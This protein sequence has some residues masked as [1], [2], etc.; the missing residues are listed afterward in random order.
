MDTDSG[1]TAASLK[2]LTVA[3]FYHVLTAIEEYNNPAQ[4]DLFSNA[5]KSFAF[6]YLSEIDAEFLTQELNLKE[7]LANKILALL[8][9]T[10]SLAFEIENLD[11]QGIRLCTVFDGSYPTKLKAQ[12]ADM[13]NSL[14]EPPLL[15]CCGDLSIAEHHFAGFV[16][17]RNVD[18]S[19]V[20]WTREAVRRIQ[21]RAE[22]ENR[23]FGIVSGGAE[24]ID[25]ASEEEALACRMPV[26]E[27]SKSMRATL[28][29]SACINAIM[30]DGMLLLS[31]IN[32][33]RTLSRMDATA[34]FMNRNKYIYAM[35]DYTIVVK[36]EKGPK[37]GTWAGATEA[38]K[39]RISKVYVRDIDAEGNRDLIERG[40]ISLQKELTDR[41]CLA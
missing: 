9:R 18:E 31:E 1:Q 30:G 24:G 22:Q 38:L 2:A 11:A 34:H 32:P 20:V 5:E 37:S 17:A 3:E 27:F 41:T 16:G 13:P 40:G 33:L 10:N 28:R 15:Y 21:N 6:E 8:K 7:D 25:R 4:S 19:D 26:I 29:D 14:R 23:V 35:S 36:S 12:L 39:R